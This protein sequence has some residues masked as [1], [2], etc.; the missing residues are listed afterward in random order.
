MKIRLPYL[1][2]R[3]PSQVGRALEHVS[4][5]PNTVKRA[6]WSNS[7]YR[8]MLFQGARDQM[9]AD[10]FYLTREALAEE[11]APGGP[12]RGH[13][14]PIVVR[15]TLG[16]SGRGKRPDSDGIIAALKSAFDGASYALSVDDGQFVQTDPALVKSKEGWTEIELEAG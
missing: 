5:Y 10:A 2:S 3:V 8:K 9:K 1:P 4:L 6:E 15:V 13:S 7:V 14:G 11:K 16:V 12:L